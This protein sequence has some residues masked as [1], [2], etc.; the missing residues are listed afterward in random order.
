MTSDVKKLKKLLLDVFSNVSC[1]YALVLNDLRHFLVVQFGSQ[2]LPLKLPFSFLVVRFSESFLCF[3]A[4][5]A[6]TIFQIVSF[7]C[8]L[9]FR[10]LF[11]D[12]LAMV[13][14]TM[15]AM[16]LL[17]MTSCSLGTIEH[18]SRSAV[19]CALPCCISVS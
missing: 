5:Q 19:L 14:L 3:L 1:P 6:N 15:L 12:V 10:L 8:C 9:S 13:L 18:Y 17:T 11:Y 2:D 4:F 7:P 16:V